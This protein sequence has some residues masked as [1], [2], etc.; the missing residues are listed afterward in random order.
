MSVSPAERVIAFFS[1]IP[2]APPL[3]SKNGKIPESIENRFWRRVDVNEVDKCWNWMGCASP[4]GRLCI[5]GFC[6]SAHRVAYKLSVAPIPIGLYV[7]H[8][9]DNPLCCNPN[10]L[11]VGTVLENNADCAAK[12]RFARGENASSAKLTEGDVRSM[13]E[14][15]KRGETLRAIG[16]IFNVDHSTARVA[17]ARK[18]WKHVK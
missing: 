5:N 9:C 12:S 11:F 14:L 4:Y 6:D 18:T 17:I 7:C 16:K 3:G 13:R 15:R 1:S 8:K 2:K 10:H